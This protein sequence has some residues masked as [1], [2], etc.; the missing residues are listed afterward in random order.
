MS[1]EFTLYCAMKKRYILSMLAIL[2]NLNL[3]FSQKE[4]LLWPDSIATGGQGKFHVQGVAV[5]SAN[6]CVYFS[7]T[8]KLIKMDLSGNLIGSVVGFLGHLGDLDIKNGRVYGSLEYKNDGIGKGII[9]GLGVDGPKDNGFYIAIFDGAKITRAD[10]SAE[11]E[12]LLQTV[13]LSE[14]VKDYEATV[15]V[16]KDMQK[17]RYACSGIDGITFGPSFGNNKD[18]KEYLYVAY[19]IYGDTNR[20]DNDHQVILQYD[21]SNW[22]NYEQP[23]LQGKLHRSGPQKPKTKYFLHTGNTSYGIQN[24]AYDHFSGNFY[25]AVYKGRKS[26]YPNY[27]LFVI[28]GKRV[29]S[30]EVI[31]S[32]NRSEKVSMLHLAA[33]GNKDINSG[34]SGWFFEWGATGISPLGNGLF[35]ISHNRKSKDGQQ[36]STIYKYKWTGDITRPFIE[37]TGK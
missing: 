15:K 23:L 34:T 1:D 36:Q 10:M 7:F 30:K 25:A 27:D 22:N 29:P 18:K 12:D 35:Y 17:H 24:L 5:D 26:V 20:N 13:Y 9:N 2:I 4:D 33:G 6:S 11:K 3:V 14:V 37:Y 8:N 28:D 31:K 16:G 21:I 32:D 19:G